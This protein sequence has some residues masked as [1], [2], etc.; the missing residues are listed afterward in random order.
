MFSPERDI[1]IN[2]SYC[3]SGNTAEEE[4]DRIEH[5]SQ[6]MGRSA[7]KVRRLDSMWLLLWAICI[8]PVTL[9]QVGSYSPVPPFAE[10]LGKLGEED[11]F[12]DENV[13][14]SYESVDDS[15][16]MHLWDSINWM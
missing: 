9:A 11:A 4:A 13:V 16:P 5:K 7:G 10:E 15:T 6:R 8:A 3:G 2:A 12:F 1:F 14:A